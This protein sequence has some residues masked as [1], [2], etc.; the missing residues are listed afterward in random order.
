MTLDKYA[1]PNDIIEGAEDALDN[2]E[3]LVKEYHQK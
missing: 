3:L 2:Y 1:S